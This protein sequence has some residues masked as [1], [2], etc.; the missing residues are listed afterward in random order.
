MII[1]K[2]ECIQQYFSIEDWQI[3]KGWKENYINSPEKKEINQMFYASYIRFTYKI[4]KENN[5][6]WII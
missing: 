1:K 5:D 3:K 4:L 6:C 2:L